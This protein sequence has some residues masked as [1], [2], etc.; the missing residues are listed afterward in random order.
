MIKCQSV[1]LIHQRMD[2]HANNYE[3]HFVYSERLDRFK[4]SVVFNGVFL[5]FFFWPFLGKYP[6]NSNTLNQTAA[7]YTCLYTTQHMLTTLLTSESKLIGVAVMSVCV[8]DCSFF[9][10]LLEFFT[11][12]MAQS[13]SPSVEV[14]FQHAASKGGRQRVSAHKLKEPFQHVCARVWCVF[15]REFTGACLHV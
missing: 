12:H 6:V 4:V 15:L 14:Q 2:Q 13:I 9:T 3:T 1:M 7:A 8:K 10:F 5:F 11:S